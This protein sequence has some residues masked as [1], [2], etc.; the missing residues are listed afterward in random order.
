MIKGVYKKII[1]VAGAVTLGMM[2]S[3]YGAAEIIVTPGI[4]FTVTATPRKAKKQDPRPVSVKEFFTQYCNKVGG[5]VPE[6]FRQIPL[7]IPAVD[8]NDPLYTALQKCVY[9]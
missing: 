8:R 5:G 4:N 2:G 1:V 6:V 3:V 9:L 7:R